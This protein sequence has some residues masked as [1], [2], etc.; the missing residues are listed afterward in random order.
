MNKFPV[1]FWQPIILRP[2]L[3]RNLT[4]DFWFVKTIHTTF[5]PS[6]IGFQVLLFKYPENQYPL[7]VRRSPVEKSIMDNDGNWHV[8]LGS[9]IVD[10]K[11]NVDPHRDIDNTNS[12]RI[13]STLIDG[14]YEAKL[15]GA[16]WTKYR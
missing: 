11:F 8:M 1:T 16:G 7:A 10:P 9:I 6:R 12:G 2:T 13:W 14:N 5:V 3:H 4:A 15:T